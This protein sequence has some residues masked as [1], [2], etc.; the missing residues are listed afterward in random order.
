M[1]ELLPYFERELV[2]LNTMGRELSVLYPKLAAEL[3]L[4]TDGG[5][6]PH[7]KR[8]I[9]ACALLNARIARKLDDDYPELTEALLETMYPHFLRGVPSCSIVRVDTGEGAGGAAAKV[10]QASVVRRGTEMASL[11][12]KGTLCRFRST[13]EMT[14]IPAAVARARFDAVIDA[15]PR[16]VLPPR[17]SSKIS[18]TIES[19]AVGASIA[20]WGLDRLRIYVDGEASFC[21]ALIDCLFMQVAAAYLDMDDGASWRKLDKPPIALAGFGD[22]DALLPAR[23]TEHPAYR[24]LT[25]YFAFAEKFHFI[26]VDLGALVP[27]L[28]PGARRFTLHFAVTGLHSDAIFARILKPLTPRNLLL[29][30]VPVV[31]LFRQ[32][33]TPIRITHRTALYD[34]IPSKN[35]AD[36]CEVYSIDAVHVI[37]TAAGRASDIEYRPYYALRHGEGMDRKDRFWFQ[38]RTDTGARGQ[39]LQ[40]GFA[41]AD[42]RLSADEE[43]VASLDTTCTNGERAASMSFGAAGGDLTTE[44]ATNG[45]PLRM[46]RKPTTPQHFALGGGVHWRLIS[47]LALNHR[48]LASLDAFREMLTLYNLPR[49]AVWQRQIAGVTGLQAGPTT[50]WIRNPQ[51]AS[52]VH[53]TEI[54]MTLDEAAFA[55]TGV[56]VFAQVVNHFFGLYVHLNSFTQLVVLSSQSEKELLR[57]EP[58]NGSLTLV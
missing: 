22:G 17:V 47:Q 36:G 45:L 39:R 37:K 31:N 25:E 8:L 57:C 48:S 21:A 56:Y 23:P 10:E 34:V 13:S 2:Y 49:S 52:L 18:I 6:D 7:I 20:Q 24:L 11:N 53:G 40:I 5:E 3:G 4:G 32:A 12:S 28:P 9:Q 19:T 14:I 58:R 44:C 26:D 51:G 27:L 15:P 33:A 38:R 50:A 46:L 16:I 29:G 30:C 54:R 55:G 35:E 42:F 43:C 1:D 41:D